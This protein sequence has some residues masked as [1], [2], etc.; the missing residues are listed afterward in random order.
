MNV[1]NSAGVIRPATVS[2]A[3]AT[4]TH[5]WNSCT[6]INMRRRSRMSA[7]AP[8]GSA[9]TSTG[10]IAATCTIATSASAPGSST[11]SHCAPTVCIQV[12]IALPTC[13]SHSARNALT[14]NG[15]HA[16]SFIGPR[17]CVVSAIRPPTAGDRPW[18]PTGEL[19]LGEGVIDGTSSAVSV[20]PVVDQRAGRGREFETRLQLPP[21]TVRCVS[22]SGIPKW[23]APRGS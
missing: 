13:A 3:S 18:P 11:S 4:A 1:S 7:S 20:K 14:R 21:P 12:P 17:G 15:A 2:A 9:S 10:S 23:H 6:A 19:I 5:A 22:Q 8:D 16:D